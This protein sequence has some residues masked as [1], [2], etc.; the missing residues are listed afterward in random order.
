MQSSP[1]SSS[2]AALYASRYSIIPHANSVTLDAMGKPNL[3]K[4]PAVDAKQSRTRCSYY[5][6]TL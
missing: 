3:T 1:Y 5:K 4:S 6:S 2:P